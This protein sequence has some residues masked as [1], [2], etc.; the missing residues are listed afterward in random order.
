MVKIGSKTSGGKARLATIVGGLFMAGF[1][2]VLRE[3]SVREAL[4]DAL[5]G[6][7]DDEDG[8]RGLMVEDVLTEI[9]RIDKNIDIFDNWAYERFVKIGLSNGDKIKLPIDQRLAIFNNIGANFAHFTLGNISFEEMT[10]KFFDSLASALLPFDI[11]KKN[12]IEASAVYDVVSTFVDNITLGGQDV[13]SY[14]TPRYATD[15]LSVNMSKVLF[16][17]MYGENPDMLA[18][19]KTRPIEVKPE[20]FK[21]VS[22]MLIPSLYRKAGYLLLAKPMG[23]EIKPEDA[24]FVNKFWEDSERLKSG[25]QYQIISRVKDRTGRLYDAYREVNKLEEAGRYEEA[26][27]LYDETFNAMHGMFENLEYVNNVLKALEENDIRKEAIKN[28]MF[29]DDY[30]ES[31]GAE[32]VKAM[33]N[34][35][36]EIFYNELVPISAK[37]QEYEKSN[38]EDDYDYKNVFIR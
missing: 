33:E 26:A 14:T 15:E 12:P 10:G 35:Y 17:M 4:L 34:N 19:D 23:M 28:R 30:K 32:E 5:G 2:S 21:K 31:I 38:T 20:F 11:D 8:L 9:E 29:V 13:A 18:G 37:M 27:K 3:D 22:G 6:D 24:P 1:L 25:N 36:N 16:E 7:D